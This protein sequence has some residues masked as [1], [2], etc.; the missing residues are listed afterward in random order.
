MDKNHPGS[1]NPNR[2]FWI[3][4]ANQTQKRLS[5]KWVLYVSTIKPDWAITLRSSEITIEFI[6]RGLKMM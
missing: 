1:T 2:Y 3:K 4:D 6:H 5:T